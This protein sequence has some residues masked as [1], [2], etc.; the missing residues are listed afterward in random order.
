MALAL[1]NLQ[2]R[3]IV[4][5]TLMPIVGIVLAFQ[6]QLKKK[7]AILAIVYYF[8]AGIGITAGLASF[9]PLSH[10]LTDPGY[11]RLWSHQAYKASF[12]LQLYLS[13]AGAA[14]F[15]GSIL[16]WCR[17]H[18]THHRYVDTDRDPHS[19][20]AGFWHAHM[21]WL[22]VKP[23]SK[24]PATDVHDLNRNP[25]VLWQDNNF[26]FIATSA[27]LLLPTLF[28][29]LLWDD[30]HGGLV[31]A[32]ILR[33]FFFQQGTFCVNSLAHWLGEQVYDDKH[34]PRDH[35]IT[36]LVTFGEGYHNFHYEFPGDCRNGVRWWQY[37]PNKWLIWYWERLGMA[38]ELG[39]YEWNVIGKGIYQQKFKQLEK[40]GRS[41]DW[42]L[43]VE[44]LPVMDWK[45]VEVA[46]HG[47]SG[48]KL[49]VIG[50][51]V[52]DVE[53]FVDIHP[54]GKSVLGAYI[55]KDGTSGFEGG[56]YARKLLNV[57]R[58]PKDQS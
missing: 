16:E 20:E 51:F 4:A 7:T 52:H 23:K 58:Y 26:E 47:E 35:L 10:L 54:G 8:I 31:Y 17:N 50:K 37:D 12:C 11:H 48:S 36:A 55:G 41:L 19:I 28:A 15:Q 3:N 46:V 56:V 27:G 34:S 43:P 38:K 25:I 44:Q 1:E 32:G 21:G 40:E 18:R 14:C 24:P 5:T 30:W 57:H 39:R 49:I 53:A 6:I 33:I 2:Y 13:V 45:E 42:G 9:P 29:G 22:M